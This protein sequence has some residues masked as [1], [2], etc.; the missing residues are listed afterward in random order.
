VTRIVWLAWEY[1]RYG[2]RR[3]TALLHWE[4]WRVNHKQVERIWREEGLEG[5][6]NSQSGVSSDLGTGR[7]LPEL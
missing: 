2:F 7:S 6:R 3:I 4:G 1:G 5:L